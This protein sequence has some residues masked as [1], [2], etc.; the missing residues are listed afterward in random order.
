MIKR[1]LCALTAL[2][3]FSGVALAAPPAFEDVDTNK[4]GII[5]MEEAV[6]VEGLDMS[7]ADSNGDGQLTKQEYEAAAK[8]L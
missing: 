4:D 8:K 6:K 7:T 5:V 2:G 3:M 1:S